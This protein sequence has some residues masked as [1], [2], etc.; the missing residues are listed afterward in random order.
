L[1]G[2]AVEA[3]GRDGDADGSTSSL[4]LVRSVAAAAA[5]GFVSLVG[6]V[7]VDTL[8]GELADAG[9]PALAESVLDP[10]DVAPE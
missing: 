5:F 4:L 8:L 6:G 3:D 2:V 7:G 9:L 10:N 1:E